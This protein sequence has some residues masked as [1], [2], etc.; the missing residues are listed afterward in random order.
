ML[1]LCAGNGRFLR[2]LL[3]YIYS[4]S[5]DAYLRLSLFF[6]L[7]DNA[8]NAFLRL[9]QLLYAPASILC[10]VRRPGSRRA[11]QLL[12]AVAD[13]YVNKFLAFIARL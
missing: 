5:K 12:R 8:K 3:S 1:I 2:L 4:I 13:R 11:V 6:L 9:K 7:F 10:Y